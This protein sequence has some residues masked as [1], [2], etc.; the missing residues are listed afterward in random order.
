[1]LLLPQLTC[2]STNDV[3]QENYQNFAKNKKVSMRRIMLLAFL[4]NLAM[5]V[6]AQYANPN[7]QW[8]YSTKKIGTD[9]FDLIVTANIAKGYHLYSQFIGE[10]GPIP[11]SFTFEKTKDVC[12]GSR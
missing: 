5:P 1:M 11:T 9:Q 3:V 4:L 6:F 10:G 12:S 2:R 7:V 8:S